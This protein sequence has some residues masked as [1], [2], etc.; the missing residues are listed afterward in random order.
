MMLI[1]AQT[2]E[3]IGIICTGNVGGTETA[4]LSEVE[5]NSTEEEKM[6]FVTAPICF[7]RRCC[8]KYG[9]DGMPQLP[10]RRQFRLKGDFQS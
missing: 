7:Y 6:S 4:I 3:F 2:I 10:A 5:E 9:G 8:H 1:S